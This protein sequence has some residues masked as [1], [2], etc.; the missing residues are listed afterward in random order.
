MPMGLFMPLFQARLSPILKK[1]CDRLLW[2]QR[3]RRRWPGRPREDL[4][5]PGS[6]CRQ[7]WNPAPALMASVGVAVRAWSSR[8]FSA[9]LS[10]SFQPDSQHSDQEIPARMLCESL[11][12][13]EPTP[14]HRR[15]RILRRAARAS[16]RGASGAPPI[17]NFLHGLL[18]HAGQKG[19]GKANTAGP[20][21]SERLH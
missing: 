3:F 5:R 20:R 2:R 14:R 21:P 19:Y 7:R 17:P 13:P 6:V 8:S 12:L 11:L 1:R 16:P 4:P 10:F 9:A 18:V 15:R